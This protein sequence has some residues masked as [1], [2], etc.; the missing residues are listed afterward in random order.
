MDISSTRFNK[1]SRNIVSGLSLRFS[2]RN[3]RADS[4]LFLM[5]YS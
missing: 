1:S 5:V 3:S 4:R 2:C